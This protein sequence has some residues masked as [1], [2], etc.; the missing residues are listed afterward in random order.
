MVLFDPSTE[1]KVQ[2]QRQVRTQPALPNARSQL[3][4][5]FQQLATPA[6]LGMSQFQAY[7]QHRVEI[8]ATAPNVSQR[9]STVHHYVPLGERNH[10]RTGQL[11]KTPPLETVSQRIEE[12]TRQCQPV[13]RPSSHA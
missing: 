7:R 11:A 3:R 4:Q 6:R 10:L 1:T 13:P 12:A 9:V 8:V 5:S 2:Q